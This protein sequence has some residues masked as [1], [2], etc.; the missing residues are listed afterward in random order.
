M[1]AGKTI[2]HI[3]VV[4]WTSKE[5]GSAL[6]ATLKAL[7]W[8]DPL[9]RS[10]HAEGKV[11]FACTQSSPLNDGALND[12]AQRFPHP[13]EQTMSEIESIGPSVNPHDRLQACVVEWMEEVGQSV[14]EEHAYGLPSKWEALGDLIV[15]P[16]DAF[17]NEA[18]VEALG[19]ATKAQTNQ[20]WASVAQALGGS[21]LARQDHIT[22]N[23]LRSPRIEML[24]G[25]STWVE[26]SDYGVHFGFDASKVMFSSGN[27]T[28][29]HRIGSIDMKGETVVDAYAGAGYYTLPMLVRSQAVRVHACEMNPASIE[30]LRWA[31][32]KNGVGDLLSVHE[33]DNQTTMPGLAGVADRCHLGLLPSSEA[34]W[35]HALACL[36]PSGGWLHIHM[37]VE[38]EKVQAWSDETVHALKQFA[39][40]SG[41]NWSIEAKHIER[42]KSYSPGVLH[43]VLDVQCVPNRSEV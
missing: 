1:D 26:F 11:G 33:G 7:H 25:E 8:L 5:N 35:Q 32:S 12:L 9:S 41:R 21:R 28:E 43:V 27:V 10:H 29:R 37:N 31:A 23:E 22:D 2:T 30:G 20:L 19:A 15:I 13:F 39:Q 18:W 24:A 38:K 42:V 16:L 6:H 4:V 34:V 3:G 14:T 40:D 17:A 36:K